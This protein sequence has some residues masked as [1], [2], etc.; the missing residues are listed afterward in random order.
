M[1]FKL[2]VFFSSFDVRY[3]FEERIK[4]LPNNLNIPLCVSCCG[5][6]SGFVLMSILWLFAIITHRRDVFLFETVIREL[7]YVPYLVFFAKSKQN[8]NIY[9]TCF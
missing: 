6:S 2:E 9:E 8:N 3:G 4:Q 7:R 1:I 5:S